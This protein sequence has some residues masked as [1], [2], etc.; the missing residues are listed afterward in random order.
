MNPLSF[1]KCL[2]DDTRLKSLLL[3]QETGEACVCD[4]MRALQLEQPKISRHLAGLRK[5]QIVQDERRGKWVFYKVHPQLPQWAK[6]V[7]AL[8]AQDN[9]SFYEDALARLQAQSGSC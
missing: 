9:L 4:L 6:Q 1:Y 3:I 7:L 2:A 8:S 5:C